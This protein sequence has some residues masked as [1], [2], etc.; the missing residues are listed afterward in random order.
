MDRA[1]ATAECNEE[2]ATLKSLARGVHVWSALSDNTEVDAIVRSLFKV[3]DAYAI[4]GGAGEYSVVYDAGSRR[5]F[6]TLYDSVRPLGYT[7]HIF[8]TKEEASLSVLKAD[9]AKASTPMAS[10]LLVL[11]S[12]LAIVGAGAALGLSYSHYFGGSSL[13][14]AA[15]FILGVVV[16]LL[17]RDLVQR[18][19]AR[20]A[21]GL[22]TL[23]Y[24]LPNIP[25]FLALPVLYFLP[26]FGAITFVRSPAYDRDALFDF[27]FWGSIA[28]VAVT[29]VVA[30]AGVSSTIVLSQA[31]YAS[32]F[33]TGVGVLSHP[34]SV[35]Q[36]L[37]AD[38]MAALNVGPSVP[39][40]GYA[41]LS[42][43]STAA[44]VGFL[45]ALFGMM[46]AALFDGGRMATLILGTRGSRIT[47]LAT[48]F[49]LISIDSPN[50][51]VVFLLIFLLAA[52]QTSNETLDSVSGISQSRK[53]LFILAMVL[54][55]L[56]FPIPQTFFTF[57][58]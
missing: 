3:K 7:P 29:M 24:Y 11:L 8:G 31:Q 26:T 54:V 49:A 25:V 55:F 46:P 23:H 4:E 51:W 53:I 13:L 57:T 44:W 15:T 56:C 32:M 38:V 12:L 17:A 28:A 6:R 39:P 52:V 50:Y 30:L 21:G 18:Y 5:A 40:G 36:S 19:F 14:D 35:L 58:I 47:T 22:S 43:L 45:L 37:A 9:A 1:C 2:G 41:F 48:A 10:V 16:V 34:A 27:Y 42:P 20:K 33:G